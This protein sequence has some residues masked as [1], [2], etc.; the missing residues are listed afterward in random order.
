MIVTDEKLLR[1]PCTDASV[2][3]IGPIIDQLERELKR[4]GEQGL[5]GIGLA[6]PQIGILRNIAIVRLGNGHDV[7]LVN[8][9]IEKGFDKTIFEHEGCLSFPGRYEKTFRYQE[10]YVIDNA[11]SPG[12]F[13][14]TGLMAICAQHEIDHWIGKL[15]PDLALPKVKQSKVRPND[16]CPCNSGKKYKKCCGRK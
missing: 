5:S 11:V 9:K 4:S 1:R 13:I 16:Q 15:L 7:N 3:E 14:C 2:D 12:S 8:C 6:A 10:I